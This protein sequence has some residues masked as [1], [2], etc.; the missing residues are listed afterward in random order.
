MSTKVKVIRMCAKTSDACSLTFLDDKENEVGSRDGYVPKYFP[1]NHYGDYV[2]FD[3][4]V[5]TGKILNWTTP[6]QEIIKDSFQ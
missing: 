4:D 2:E 3:I 5:E 6:T 1:G